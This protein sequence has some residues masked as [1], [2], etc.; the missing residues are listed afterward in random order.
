MEKVRVDKWLWAARMFKTRSMASD[1][2][3]G[4]HVVVNG[5]PAKSSKNVAVGDTIEALTPGGPRVLEVAGLAGKRGPAKLAIS[6]YVDHTPPPPPTGPVPGDPTFD[7]GS[8]K[9]RKGARPTKRD[10]RRFN[11]NKGW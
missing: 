4:G 1:A 8:R 2:C 10:R 9:G 7:R 6:L 5:E 11:P 3:A